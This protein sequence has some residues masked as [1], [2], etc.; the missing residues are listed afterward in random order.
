MFV[1]EHKPSTKCRKT[2]GLTCRHVIIY[3]YIRIQYTYAFVEHI[4]TLYVYIITCSRGSDHADGRTVYM[5]CY[6]AETFRNCFHDRNIPFYLTALIES[7]LCRIITVAV[8]VLPSIELLIKVELGRKD[9]QKFIWPQR[10][11][12]VYHIFIHD[13]RTGCSESPM[14]FDPV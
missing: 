3:Y 12:T 4:V 2:H 5:L 1:I 9:T 10:L 6:S 11:T 8:G 13:I 7:Y 14:Q